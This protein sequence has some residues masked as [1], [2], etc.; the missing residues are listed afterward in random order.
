MKVAEEDLFRAV[1]AEGFC[2]IGLPLVSFE[3]E[4]AMS[5]NWSRN[6]SSRSIR[7]DRRRPDIGADIVAGES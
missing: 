2:R 1:A 5:M 6:R 4:C 7:V 3:D